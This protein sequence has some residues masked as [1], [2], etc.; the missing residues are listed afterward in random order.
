MQLTFGLLARPQGAH[1]RK[2]ASALRIGTWT[3]AAEVYQTI[4][5]SSR[6]AFRACG[7]MLVAQH[8]ARVASRLGRKCR[9]ALSSGDGVVESE[10]AAV[11]LEEAQAPYGKLAMAARINIVC[12]WLLRRRRPPLTLARP[13][14]PL[15]A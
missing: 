6:C 1:R 14:M 2:P 9:I 15:D 10:T 8:P 5:K 12:F 4:T 11:R 7:R 13:K 3:R